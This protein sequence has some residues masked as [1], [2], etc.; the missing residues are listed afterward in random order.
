[1]RTR[2]LAA[3]VGVTLALAAAAPAHS[4]TFIGLTNN[5]GLIQ[6][7]S[8]SPGY[9]SAELPITGLQQSESIHGID[10][11][12]ATG[13]LFG[14]GSSNT[15]YSIN[16]ATGAATAVGPLGMTPSGT[17]FGFDFNPVSDRL[18]ITTDLD[19]VLVVDPATGGATAGPPLM[20]T[21]GMQN[22]YIIGVAFSNN[23]PGAP[24]TTQYG[25]DYGNNDLVII[26]PMTG[27]ITSVGDLGP[28]PS[29]LT[30][31][32]ITRD[33]VAWFAS[34][35]FFH[36]VN[37][38]TGQ[39]PSAGTFPGGLF[40]KGLAAVPPTSGTPGTPGTPDGPGGDG[41]PGDFDLNG[42]VDAADYVVWR[43]ATLNQDGFTVTLRTPNGVRMES[44]TDLYNE[45]RANFGR[46]SGSR[47]ASAAQRRKAIR[48]A[49]NTTTLRGQQSKR[50]RIRLT[51]AGRRA[52]RGYA[53]KRLRATLTLR[54]TYRPA[55]GAARQTRTFKQKVTLRVKRKRR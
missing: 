6:F 27:L 52:V 10:F 39:A 48:F 22:P 50:V 35:P 33:G 23:T 28:S 3:V 30:G 45:W 1:M 2:I 8:G 26:D 51:K 46:V 19:Q 16:P 25:L 21:G 54:V 38:T 14:V 44:R 53:R 15:L 20:Y 42:T 40:I 13:Q 12:P 5:N 18:F 9:P 4:A 34:G 36:M 47:H 24:S 31:F 17:M 29:P 55:V 49:R 43:G 7:D 41:L 37:L 32:D 11:R